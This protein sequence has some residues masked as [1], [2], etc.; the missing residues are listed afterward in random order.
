MRQLE[1]VVEHDHVRSLLD[2][3]EAPRPLRLLQLG[4][5]LLVEALVLVAPVPELLHCV[6]VEVVRLHVDGGHL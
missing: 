1:G 5:P 2:R 4:P 6:H 3:R